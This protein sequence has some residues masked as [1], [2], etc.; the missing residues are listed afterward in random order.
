MWQ[1]LNE[2]HSALDSH[3]GLD[4]HLWGLRRNQKVEAPGQSQSGGIGAK[5]KKKMGAPVGNETCRL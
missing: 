2:V 1:V 3:S 4:L 5:K